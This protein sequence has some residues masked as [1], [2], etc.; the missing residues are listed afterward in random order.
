M[1]L[2]SLVDVATTKPEIEVADIF[3]QHFDDYLQGHHC[4]REEF[5]AVRAI[6]NCRTAAM[7]GHVRVCDGCGKVQIAY[8]SCNNR[9]CPK[10]GA[11]EKAQWLAAQGVR[12]LPV[13][14]FHVVF[15]VDHLV[16]GVAYENPE[17]IYDLL[18]GSMNEVLRAFAEQYLGGKVGYTAVLH[19]WGQSLQHHLHLHCMVTGGALVKTAEG[20]EWRASPTGF[21]LPVVALS[22]AF[23][24]K[25]CQ[26]L[27]RLHERKKLK[28]VGECAE[29][30]VPALVGRMQAKQWEVYIGAPPEKAT[31]THLLDY[32][33]RYVH[34]TA[35]SNHRI[36]KLEGGKVTFE[37]YDNREEDA[38]GKGTQKVMTLPAVEFIR[39]FL[40]HVL[41]FQY[42]RVRHYGLYASGNTLWRKAVRLLVGHSF[43]PPEAPRLELGEWLQSL[44]VEDAFRCPF[45]QEG[46][47]RLGRDFAPIRGFALWL[48]ALLGVPVLGKEAAA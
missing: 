9:S 38:T 41:P 48:L 45:C 44:G 28:L 19:T 20:Y 34:R 16:N 46:T 7:G 33:G 10:C 23:R 27:R 6:M 26:G 14:H 25:F 3:R 39:R 13:P 5:A 21:L 35:I 17:E 8:N 12:L 42:K 4:T 11:F 15:T 32:L 47:M 36:R 22:A 29:L 40:R 43:E 31:V 18:F 2:R 30:D 37:Y 1:I 24:D